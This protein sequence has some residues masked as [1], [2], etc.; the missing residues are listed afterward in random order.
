ML[1][2]RDIELL[3]GATAFDAGA[4]EDEMKEHVAARL[5]IGIHLNVLGPLKELQT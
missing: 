5:S 1:Q 2:R 4:F 3:E